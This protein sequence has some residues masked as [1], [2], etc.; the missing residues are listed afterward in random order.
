MPVLRILI[1]GA[2]GVGLLGEG[3]GDTRSTRW[4]FSSDASTL[5]SGALTVD[6]SAP[7][8]IMRTF[9]TE[10]RA[11]LGD[12]ADELSSTVSLESFSSR[13]GVF[14]TADT[15]TSEMSSIASSSNSHSEQRG[16]APRPWS[17]CPA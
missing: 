3:G 14:S 12:D 13:G 7:T 8:L 4:L 10:Q 2:E 16:V 6:T 1:L 9:G 11:W 17:C 5:S 15:L